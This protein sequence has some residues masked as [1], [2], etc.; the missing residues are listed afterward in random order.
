MTVGPG[1]LAAVPA[2]P[3]PRFT[4]PQFPEVLVSG[5]PSGDLRPW[6]PAAWPDPSKPRP[7]VHPEGV[8]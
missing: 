2:K 1:D 6:S 4:L 5:L 8:G 3:G 7:E